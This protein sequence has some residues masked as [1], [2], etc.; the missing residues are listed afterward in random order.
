MH[1]DFDNMP[2]HFQQMLPFDYQK[3]RIQKLKMATNQNQA[4]LNLIV[5]EY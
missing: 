2:K 1:R 5:Q 3:D 4:F